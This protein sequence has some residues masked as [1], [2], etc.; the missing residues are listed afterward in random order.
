V[1]KTIKEKR[2]LKKLGKMGKIR[3]RKG[4]GEKKRKI[5]SSNKKP[6]K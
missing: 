6:S 2:T 1:D 3:Y 5:T 4:N